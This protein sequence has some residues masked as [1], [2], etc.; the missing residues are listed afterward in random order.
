MLR[1]QSEPESW[2]WFSLPKA[3]AGNCGELPTQGSPAYSGLSVRQLGQTGALLEGN[4]LGNSPTA[5]GSKAKIGV[6]TD[7]PC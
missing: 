5:A 7:G 4:G 6:Q 2:R 3:T 1:L